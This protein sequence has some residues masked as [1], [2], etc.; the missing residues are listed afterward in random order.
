MDAKNLKDELKVL[1]RLG[2][3]KVAGLVC[4]KKAPVTLRIEVEVPQDQVA[5]VVAALDL[6]PT[7]RLRSALEAILRGFKKAEHRG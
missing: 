1:K 2:T 7:D 3:A 6:E 5:D 4:N